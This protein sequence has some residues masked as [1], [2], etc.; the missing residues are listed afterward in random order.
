MN[1]D[2]LLE[3][4]L[5]R[6]TFLPPSFYESIN[7]LKAELAATPPPPPL[8]PKPET[9]SP[10][11]TFITGVRTG[12]A[13][14]TEVPTTLGKLGETIEKAISQY[15]LRPIGRIFPEQLEKRFTLPAERQKELAQRERE[16]VQKVTQP[17]KAIIEPDEE[18][19]NRVLKTADNSILHKIALYTGHFVGQIPEMLLWSTLVAPV[20]SPLVAGSRILAKNINLVSPLLTKVTQKA[21]G[22]VIPKISVDT[23]FFFGLHHLEPSEIKQVLKSG[24][25]FG[26]ITYTLP[27][28]FGYK[29]SPISY[30]IAGSTDALVNNNMPLTDS[31]IQGGLLGIFAGLTGPPHHRE[32]LRRL[33]E[34]GGMTKEE[35][36]AFFENPQQHYEKAVDAFIKGVETHTEIKAGDLVTQF[37]DF[38]RNK[39]RQIISAFRDA[40]KFKETGE[41]PPE[42]VDALQTIKEWLQEASK[43]AI[44]QKGPRKSPETILRTLAKEITALG[45]YDAVGDIITNAQTKLETLIDEMTP[46]PQDIP[47]G[48]KYIRTTA[49]LIRNAFFDR[50]NE[51]R[52]SIGL[53]LLDKRNFWSSFENIKEVCNE[54]L[55]NLL[56]RP[57][58]E[59]NQSDIR[60]VKQGFEAM[61]SLIKDEID[62]ITSIYTNE[63]QRQIADVTPETLP[64]IKRVINNNLERLTEYYQTLRLVINKDTELRPDSIIEEIRTLQRRVR[65]ATDP[66]EFIDIGKRLEDISNTIFDF[67]NNLFTLYPRQA[68][69]IAEWITNNRINIALNKPITGPYTT[70]LEGTVLPPDIDA[71]IK[72]HSL[73]VKEIEN[74]IGKLKGGNLTSVLIDSLADKHHTIV[75]GAFYLDLRPPFTPFGISRIISQMD[76]NKKLINDLITHL[77]DTGDIDRLGLLV[78]K[79]N[80]GNILLNNRLGQAIDGILGRLLKPQKGIP[81]IRTDKLFPFIIIHPNRPDIGILIFDTKTEG[82]SELVAQIMR[83][84]RQ[85]QLPIDLLSFKMTSESN[86]S[87]PNLDVRTFF[88]HIASAVEGAT[89]SVFSPIHPD[90]VEIRRIPPEI[91]YHAKEVIEQKFKQE[92]SDLIAETPDVPHPFTEIAVNKAWIVHAPSDKEMPLKIRAEIQSLI[93][94]NA[95]TTFDINFFDIFPTQTKKNVE[96]IDPTKPLGPDAGA[97]EAG[98]VVKAEHIDPLALDN[99]TVTLKDHLSPEVSNLPELLAETPPFK[100]SFPLFSRIIEASKEFRKRIKSLYEEHLVNPALRFGAVTRYF[101]D[102]FRTIP[103]INA[104]TIAEMV[105]LMFKPIRPEDLNKFGWLFALPRVDRERY[106][107]MD[108]FIK[109]RPDIRE[110]LTDAQMDEITRFCTDLRNFWNRADVQSIAQSL[111]YFF[112]RVASILIDENIMTPGLIYDRWIA[113]TLNAAIKETEARIIDVSLTKGTDSPEYKALSQYLS[114]LRNAFEIVTQ[115]GIPYFPRTYQAHEGV[116]FLDTFAQ[117]LVNKAVIN[118]IETHPAFRNRILEEKRKIAAQRNIPEEQLDVI[119][120][121]EAIRNNKALQEEVVSFIKKFGHEIKNIR[122]LIK[123]VSPE[124]ELPITGQIFLD[125]LMR[126][127]DQTIGLL[128]LTPILRELGVVHP[129]KSSIPE[130]VLQVIGA[131]Y[132]AERG[133]PVGVVREGTPIPSHERKIITIDEALA[134]A[135][136]H[137]LVTITDPVYTITNYMT[138]LTNKLHLKYLFTTLINV[139]RS[140]I[141]ETLGKYTKETLP[142]KEAFMAEIADDVTI[143]TPRDEVALKTVFPGL[144]LSKFGFV[145]IESDGLVRPDGTPIR[146]IAPYLADS[147]IHPLLW[148]WLQDEFYVPSWVSNTRMS[149]LP[150]SMRII[151]GAIKGWDKLSRLTKILT[152]YNPLIMTYNNL[153]Q[154]YLLGV[155]NIPSIATSMLYDLPLMTLRGIRKL[156]TGK[157]T[158]IEGQEYKGLLGNLVKGIYD[159]VTESPLYQAAKEAGLF[160][161]PTAFREDAGRLAQHIH[162]RLQNDPLYKKA[163][164]AIVDAYREAQ[165]FIGIKGVKEIS[166]A[167]MAVYRE[168]IQFWTWKLDEV[169]RMASL[170]WYLTHRVKETEGGL[171]VKR[172]LEFKDAVD[173]VRRFMINYRGIPQQTRRALN[174]VLLT[175]TYRIEMAKLYSRIFTGKEGWQPI[176][177][178]LTA[179]AMAFT[180]KWWLR[181]S[182]IKLLGSIMAA[183]L[184]GFTKEALDDIENK[185]TEYKVDLHFNPGFTLRDWY[186]VTKAI[187]HINERVYVLPGALFEIEKYIGRS[188]KYT[189]YV[190]SSRPTH[191][192]LS[193]LSNRDWRGNQI[194]SP[195]ASTLE[196]AT[197]IF[198]Y[199][200][201]TGFLPF[202]EAAVSAGEEKW[203]AREWLLA[204]LAITHYKSQRPSYRYMAYALSAERRVNELLRRKIRAAGRL[205]PD[206]ID[207]YNR[208]MQK[209]AVIHSK[210]AEVMEREYS[211]ELDDL[212]A[213]AYANLFGISR[214]RF[215]AEAE[216]TLQF[217]NNISDTLLPWGSEIEEE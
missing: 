106:L 176:A 76:I 63:L 126:L 191:M 158:V 192:L 94:P 112:G 120:T 185:Y 198:I 193:I 15:Y 179:K 163:F 139:S 142:S 10:F 34:K 205:T 44:I 213:N 115:E 56:A 130:S 156:V 181:A 75:S 24:V 14:I 78:I 30:F 4:P 31:L 211:P 167:M 33:L 208:E 177:N 119:S 43:Q 72:E 47:L 95:R 23:L 52:K 84:L 141:S 39:G 21:I 88:D 99:K 89:F 116:L 8:S 215:K 188:P 114:V 134:W 101:I 162:K 173:A 58:A 217:F 124:A 136:K 159:V 203:N 40:L 155:A 93:D 80:T 97:I 129:T 51:I 60:F 201:R 57:K 96:V 138:Y 90:A 214:E 6:I 69:L 186:H 107:N 202:T 100:I 2:K 77:R 151:L 87:I 140:K 210:T 41:K 157:G 132:T 55:E 172:P 164:N 36:E 212:L 68:P 82:A 152:F 195:A 131:G 29:F 5:G 149:N 180:V 200:L 160:L 154:M 113:S 150:L 174:L 199:A 104:K 147:Y 117:W 18:T 64:T 144:D 70:W 7:Q 91:I 92:L 127:G 61:V 86:K 137:N 74:I 183:A 153:G 109:S 216:L 22:E 53:P 161:D 98:E 105:A 103:E 166:K 168:A 133:L 3:L 62:S 146:F 81:E 111:D 143:I 145:K 73:R 170:R 35:I 1:G 17:L 45:K 66:A 194:Y 42:S 28:L 108:E 165:P 19:L 37:A 178:M 187:D 32:T 16:L 118:M 85:Q 26:T 71:T 20:A 27:K 209:I 206:I 175:P 38:Y 25:T 67:E 123:A 169:M 50:I 48:L 128:Q 46:R 184:A 122:E 190:Y 197:Q 12:L 11:T 121:I 182:F 110:K 125:S 102:M 148:R 49:E 13:Q 189:F 54:T 59:Q 171:I 9:P 83:R 79:D 65:E 204:S 196:K 135:L 207:W